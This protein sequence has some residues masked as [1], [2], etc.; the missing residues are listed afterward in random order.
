MFDKPNPQT[1]PQ[2]ATNR[3]SPTEKPDPQDPPQRSSPPLSPTE[4]K[5]Y[6]LLLQRITEQQVAD[7]LNRSPNTVHVHVRNIYRKLGIRTR[8]QLF[9]IAPDLKV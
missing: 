1:L 7:H 4:K 3:Q 6:Q 9:D 5:V 8:Q 2:R